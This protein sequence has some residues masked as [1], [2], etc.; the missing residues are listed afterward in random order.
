[1]AL[2]GLCNI[3]RVSRFYSINARSQPG[4]GLKWEKHSKMKHIIF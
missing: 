3:A 2:F 1:M 4:G